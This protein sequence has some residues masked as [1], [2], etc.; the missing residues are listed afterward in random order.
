MYLVF[1]CMPGE[2]YWRRLRSLL[3]YSCDIF[4]ALINSLCVE[5]EPQIAPG[6]LASTVPHHSQETGVV[7]A[8][9][10]KVEHN[11]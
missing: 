7:S 6:S 9:H 10:R 5:R 4:R 1:T 2:S 11:K 8:Q 3:L